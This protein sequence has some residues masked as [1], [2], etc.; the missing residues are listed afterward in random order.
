MDMK[1]HLNLFVLIF[2]SVGIF[3]CKEDASIPCPEVPSKSIL[4]IS[5]E[6]NGQVCYLDSVYP[7]AQG[8][9][10][11]FSDIRFF[12]HQI[13]TENGI[14]SNAEKFD[15][16]ISELFFSSDLDLSSSD[17]LIFFLGV[18]E[19]DN[20][21][22]PSAFPLESALNILNA[23]DM[24]WGWNPGYIFFKIEAMVDTIPDGIPLF[25]HPVVYHIG[26]SVN[27]QELRLSGLN[28]SMNGTDREVVLKLDLDLFLEGNG[29]IDLKSE[30]SSHTAPGQEA[31]SLKVSQNLKNSISVL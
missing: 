5:P 31:L 18:N 8:V 14:V 28:W 26:K 27:L 29:G 11:R 30:N 7:T 6:I 13:S 25:N 23:N 22:D 16:S 4:S 21:S 15:Y 20:S 17:S 9:D 2:V 1:N 12:G 19:P 10:I 3:S 24:H